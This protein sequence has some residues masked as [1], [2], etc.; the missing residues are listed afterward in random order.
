MA[1]KTDLMFRALDRLIGRRRRLKDAFLRAGWLRMTTSRPNTARRS[2]TTLAPTGP[3]CHA[4]ARA[5]AAAGPNSSYLLRVP[6]RRSGRTVEIKKA[7]AVRLYGPDAIWWDIGQRVLDHT[8]MQRTGLPRG[9][10]L[11]AVVRLA[12]TGWTCG[13]RRNVATSYL[14]CV[15][16]RPRLQLCVLTAASQ[17]QIESGIKMLLPERQ[18]S[19]RHARYGV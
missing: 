12:L 7:A 15:V 19:K 11:L 3:V 16:R 18:R 8:C 13:S 14:D 17:A 5:L 6:C 9:A 1:A 2:W 4:P 10:R